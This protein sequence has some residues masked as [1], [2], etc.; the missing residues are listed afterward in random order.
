[1]VDTLVL[2]TTVS[3]MLDNATFGVINYSTATT[4]RADNPHKVDLEW[5]SFLSSYEKTTV[6][7]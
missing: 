1:M 4:S 6:V 7:K 5:A 2:S 3:K